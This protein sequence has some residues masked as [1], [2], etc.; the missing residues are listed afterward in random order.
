MRNK[1]DDTLR[2]RWRPNDIAGEYVEDTT[3]EK[4][5]MMNG[6][7]EAGRFPI[8]CVSP[9]SVKENQVLKERLQ[10]LEELLKLR[11]AE[12]MLMK[13]YRKDTNK[14][15]DMSKTNDIES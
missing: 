13:N 9:S 11:D 7:T 5:P 3:D 8:T 10:T 2:K 14:T 15:Y 4:K 12:I 1:E 6:E